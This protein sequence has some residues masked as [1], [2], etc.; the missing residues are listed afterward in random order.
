MFNPFSAFNSE[1]KT[2]RSENFKVP[3]TTTPLE[4]SI[5]KVEVSVPTKPMESRDSIQAEEIPKLL[6]ELG[7]K[8]RFQV[9]LDGRDEAGW[10]YAIRD[11]HSADGSYPEGRFLHENTSTSSDGNV[12]AY[13]T[14]EEAIVF[15]KEKNGPG[16]Y[17]QAE[18]SSP[19]P[20]ASVPTELA[21]EEAEG[22]E[23]IDQPITPTVAPEVPA[24]PNSLHSDASS[25]MAE[26]QQNQQKA[27]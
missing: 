26:K 8:A 3:E 13:R 21:T 27:E 14:P 16:S 2:S 6:N 1:S 20:E 4:P 18:V 11:T 24:Q 5:S 19:A 10:R 25:V 7:L 17:V 12:K 15:A 23:L 22:S 9:G